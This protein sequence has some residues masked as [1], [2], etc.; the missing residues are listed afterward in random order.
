M[1]VEIKWVPIEDALK[2]LSNLECDSWGKD[3]DLKYIGLRI[4]TRTMDCF[5]TDRNGKA[6]DLK[7]IQAIAAL[8]LL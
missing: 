7:R 2:A 6:I 1:N 5:L 3:F 4:D 8:V